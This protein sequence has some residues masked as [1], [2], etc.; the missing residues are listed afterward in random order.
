MHPAQARGR[1][2]NY[3]I[4]FSRPYIPTDRAYWRGLIAFNSLLVHSCNERGP[5]ETRSRRYDHFSFSSFFFH[6][7]PAPGLPSS[8]VSS[9]PLLGRSTDISLSRLLLLSFSLR[10]DAIASD[11]NAATDLSRRPRE[12]P[13]SRP[14]VLPRT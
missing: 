9:L 5:R 4:S 1:Q 7:S 6:R 11:V 13:S 12:V 10:D 14:A 3:N 2:M 8:R